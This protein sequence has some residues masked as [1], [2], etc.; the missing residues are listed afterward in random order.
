M[1]PLSRP[2]DGAGSTPAE[3]PD[4]RAH[5]AIACRYVLVAQGWAMAFWCGW[6]A[7]ARSADLLVAYQVVGAGPLDR[8]SRVS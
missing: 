6:E 1:L 4:I 2:L 7:A 3:I 8:P 5:R